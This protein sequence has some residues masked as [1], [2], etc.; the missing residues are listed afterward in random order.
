MYRTMSTDRI[1]GLAAVALGA[2][3]F[4]IVIPIGVETIGSEDVGLLLRQDFWPRTIAALMVAL[5][6]A[7]TIFGSGTG[8]ERPKPAPGPRIRPM[9]VI[10]IVA[11]IAAVALAG[12]S[13]GLLIPSMVVFLIAA[14]SIDG[15]HPVTKLAFAVLVPLAL[16]LFFDKVGGISLP[17]GPIFEGVLN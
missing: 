6:L 7:V 4:F 1:L 8:A 2:A 5:G 15:G 9:G 11:I 3:Q 14:F 13:A 10:A 16:A 17:L 12:T